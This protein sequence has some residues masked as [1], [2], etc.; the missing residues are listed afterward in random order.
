MDKSF[1]PNGYRVSVLHPDNPKTVANVDVDTVAAGYAELGRVAATYEHS[2]GNVYRISDFIEDFY[3]STHV[4]VYP[5][6]GDPVFDLVAD[7]HIRT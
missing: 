6:G 5:S 4:T 1:A 2:T 3:F 7:L